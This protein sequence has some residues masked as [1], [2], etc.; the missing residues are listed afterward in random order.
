MLMEEAGLER[1]TGNGTGQ[2]SDHTGMD[3]AGGGGMGVGLL[4]SG[5]GSRCCGEDAIS[6]MGAADDEGATKAG[7]AGP[8]AQ[9]TRAVNNVVAVIGPQAA[10]ATSRWKEG[11]RGV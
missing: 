4:P 5:S 2:E 1:A 3:I 7:T 10:I 8:V 11:L 6:A 9:S